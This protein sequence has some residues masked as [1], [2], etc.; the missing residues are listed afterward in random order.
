M[1]TVTQIALGAAVAAVFVPKEHR[2]KA[3]FVGAIIGTVPDLDVFIDYGDAVS[4][5]SFHRGFSH[6]VFVLIPFALLIWLVLKKVYT[7]VKTAP[8]P[9]FF[10]IMLVL[11]THPILDAHTAYGT[12]LF[13][14]MTSPPIMWSTLFIIDPLYTLPLLIGVIAVLRNPLKAKSFKTLSLGI[15][16]SCIYLTWTLAAKTYVEN[17]VYSSLNADVDV[18]DVFTTP[19]PFNTILWRVVVLQDD[20]YL[21]GYYSF[22]NGSKRID[23]K[24]YD[25]GSD[26]I[27]EASDIWAVRRLDWFSQ[28]FI[29]ASVLND[30][31]IISDLRMGIEGSYVFVHSVAKT[32]DGAWQAT[33]S[34]QLPVQFDT[35]LITFFRQKLFGNESPDATAEP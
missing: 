20:Q 9:W 13:W 8:K 15:L 10:A 34:T 32:V 33:K 1:D 18:V 17:Q 12:Q 2:R 21:E 24:P 16:L 5:F 27:L 19:T 35:E 22:L 28:S 4:N 3:V 29:K 23:F 11:V 25:K 31:L 14:P 6:S 30:E 7:P 26:L